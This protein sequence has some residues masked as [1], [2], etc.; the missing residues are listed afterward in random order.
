MKVVHISML[1][2]STLL[3]QRKR[4]IQWKT[5]FTSKYTLWHRLLNLNI[6]RKSWEDNT[7]TFSVGEIKMYPPYEYIIKIYLNTVHYSHAIRT[8][9]WKSY[10]SL[11]LFLLRQIVL[12]SSNV[13]I[14]FSAICPLF[15]VSTNYV[16]LLSHGGGMWACYQDTKPATNPRMATRRTDALDLANW[17]AVHIGGFFWDVFDVGHLSD[18]QNRYT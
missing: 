12:G 8:A 1:Q 15:C 2:L 3:S 16:Y 13:T 17:R 4:I 7:N 5:I 10:W 18:S 11:R 6:L 9:C 14:I